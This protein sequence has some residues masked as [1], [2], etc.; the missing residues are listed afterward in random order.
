MASNNMK[1]VVVL[2]AYNCEKTL[3]QTYEAIDRSVID[4][5]V[6]VDD[7]SSDRSV[8]I[9]KTLPIHLLRHKYNRGYGSNQK[10]CYR[11]ALSLGADIVIMLHPDYQ[12]SPKLLVAM[13]SMISTGVYDCVLGSRILGVGQIASGMP[14]YKY[15]ANRFLTAFQN[16]MSK[17]KLSEFHTGYRAFS[18]KV[19]ETIP[20]ERNSENF[21]FDNQILA[22]IIFAKFRIG[23]ISCPTKYAPESS[24]INFS[25]SVRYGFG[26]LRCSIQTFCA[27]NGIIKSR[28]F[29]FD[30]VSVQQIDPNEVEFINALSQKVSS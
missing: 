23:E 28:L 6:M 25:R 5:V 9:A 27:L 18:R 14:R 20:F 19:L 12:Y 15:I 11:Y 16:L 24:S 7:A 29:D 10:T 21:I 13:A 17:H 22:Q 4:E 30:S 1:V 3:L 8:D 26:V 2:P